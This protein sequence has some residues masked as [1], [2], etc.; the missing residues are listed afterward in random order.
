MKEN[1]SRRFFHHLS[2]S[3]SSA[4]SSP[5]VH[6]SFN[7]FAPPSSLA[8][9]I[10]IHHHPLSTRLSDSLT[11]NKMRRFKQKNVYNSILS[12][13]AGLRLS[14]KERETFPAECQKRS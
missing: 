3:Q 11:Q 7:N 12:L 1:Q 9:Q 2:A 6:S 8:N 5:A 4:S 13:F 10:L 14:E